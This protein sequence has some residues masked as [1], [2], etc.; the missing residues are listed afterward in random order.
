MPMF[1]TPKPRQF[2]YKPRLYDPEKEE[3]EKLKAKYRIQ[4]GLPIDDDLM[5]EAVAKRDAQNQQMTADGETSAPNTTPINI[6]VNRHIKPITLGD[7][8]HKHE[9][10]EFHYVS[11]FDENGNL[12]T[13]IPPDMKGEA[14]KPHINRKFEREERSQFPTTLI[15]FAVLILGIMLFFFIL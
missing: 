12:R 14:V 1:Y 7:L 3:L 9:K 8:I 13:D 2:H 10:P 15:M 5:R 11:R 6:D 4:Q